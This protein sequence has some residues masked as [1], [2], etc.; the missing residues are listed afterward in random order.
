MN[1]LMNA[2]DEFAA[3]CLSRF[4]TS[5]QRVYVSAMKKALRIINKKPSEC[6]SYDELLS[7]LKTQQAA[8]KV[9]KGLRLRPFLRFLESRIPGLP[10]P[11]EKS[12]EENRTLR[13]WVVDRIE[14][15]TKVGNPSIYLR[16]DLAM[17][18][19]LCLAPE[20][21]S[22]RKWP[23]SALTPVNGS[24]A[25]TV[26]LWGKLVEVEAL[27]LPLLYWHAWRERLDRP[28]Q[29]RLYRKNWAYSEYLFPNSKGEPLK[30]QAL[31][32]AL[33]RLSVPGE[34]RIGLTPE[35]IRE[36]FLD[37]V[38]SEPHLV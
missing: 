33:A 24:Q 12:D 2:P 16:R 5:T 28:E 6:H 13:V 18:A 32:N 3:L 11:R 20:K 7:L 10:E 34:G 29:S 19:G 21:G 23:K 31:H 8:S 30:K 4:N 38:R 1:S 9:F 26:C 15:E 17:L 35:E 27:A 37:T 14:E 22:P 36:A 25:V